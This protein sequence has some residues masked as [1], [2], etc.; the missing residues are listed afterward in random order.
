MKDQEPIS[1]KTDPNQWIDRY[2]NLLYRF[3]LLRLR[4]SEWAEEVVQE[5]FVAALKGIR[6]FEGKSSESTW[7]VGIL[8]H[9]IIDWLRK[10]QEQKNMGSLEEAETLSA[11]GSGEQFNLDIRHKNSWP[12]TPERLFEDKEFWSTFYK[13]LETLPE[14]YRTVYVLREVDGLE[15]EE[16]CKIVGVTKTN[17][18][19]LLHRA[20]N[21]IRHCLAVKWFDQSKS[22]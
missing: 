1:K 19:V 13:C 8:K 16:I 20:R 7:L 21:Q 9:K 10:I 2:G 3:A 18:W 11:E 14:R 4:N 5:T 12:K 6:S 15:S 22:N 17:L